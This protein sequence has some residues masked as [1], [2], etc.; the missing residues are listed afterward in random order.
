MSWTSS[1][2]E[3]PSG[4]AVS[5]MEQMLGPDGGLHRR[6]TIERRLDPF[7]FADA[8]AF[9]P[10]IPAV[11]YV[12]A[13]AAC[14]GYPLHLQRWDGSQSPEIN[15]RRLAFEPAG[16]LLR[17]AM[18]ILSED[19]DWRGGYERVLAALGSGARRRSR[20]ASRAQQ[21]IDYTLDRLRRAGY[22]QAARPHGSSAA[23]DP[24]YEIADP[25]LAYWFSVL[26]EDADLIEG[27]QGHAV[28][29]RVN[30]RWQTH[31]ARV[32][33]NAARDHALRLVQAGDFPSATTV[34]RWWRDEVAEVDV[35]G[36]LNQQ[37]RILGEVK[38]RADG[39]TSR[40]LQLLASK[41]SYLP[42]AHQDLEQVFW[43]R[44]GTNAAPGQVRH[45]TAADM[46]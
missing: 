24:L 37:T 14:G 18:D 11:D 46:V 21:R 25:Y 2:A 40:D 4:S 44:A 10:D 29:Q 43:T 15:L 13:Y 19:L 7:S 23:A 27:G 39:P 38:W 31:L 35:L 3:L 45:Y 20:I 42:P 41:L 1:S 9:Q 34:G 17:D 26:R 30:G 16:M 33:E 12:Q 22:V 36:L 5:V 8:R 32:F 6:P 28:Q